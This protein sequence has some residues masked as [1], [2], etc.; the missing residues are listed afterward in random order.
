[1]GVCRRSED[2]VKLDN[3]GR[4]KGGGREDRGSTAVGVYKGSSSEERGRIGGR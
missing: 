3:E 2:E 4:W 1:M